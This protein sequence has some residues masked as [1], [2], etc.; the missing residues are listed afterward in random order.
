M[1]LLLPAVL[2]ETDTVTAAVLGFGVEGLDKGREL[3]G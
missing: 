2:G 1:L 3:I